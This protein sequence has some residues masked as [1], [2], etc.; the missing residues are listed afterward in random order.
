MKTSTLPKTAW[1]NRLLLLLLLLLLL[2]MLGSSQ[3]TSRA[4]ETDNTI[5]NA[6]N[7]DNAFFMFFLLKKIIGHCPMG[8]ISQL[9]YT[10][11]FGI[12]KRGKR[13]RNAKC[14][15]GRNNEQWGKGFWLS[16]FLLCIV[17]YTSIFKKASL[18]A[19]SHK[20][21]YKFWQRYCYLCRF[22]V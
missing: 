9:Y 2:F 20:D 21:V 3:E 22:V 10:I 15:M 8:T 1:K 6:N 14:R 17:R 12:V 16:R 11:F 18:S 4:T 19:G 13:M 7:T 5:S